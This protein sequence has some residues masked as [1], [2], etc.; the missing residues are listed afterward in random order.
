MLLY[1]RLH[2]T[3]ALP[4]AI[5]VLKPHAIFAS[6]LDP[7]Y[8][9]G[10]E[11][12]YS[13]PTLKLVSTFKRASLGFGIAGVYIS[14]LMTG[15]P[16]FTIE[17]SYIMAGLSV[18]PLPLVHFFTKDYVTRI[19]RVYNE[20]FQAQTMSSLTDEETL[21]IEKISF[22][23]NSFYKYL[24]KVEDLSLAEKKLGWINWKDKEGKG[25]YVSDDIGGLNM[26]RIWGKVEKQSGVDTGRSVE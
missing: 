24:V 21:V 22:T 3:R 5:K 16:L 15:T 4:E 20:D 7:K 17:A 1:R 14:Q 11:P 13:A 23:G 18:I 25:Y 19:F 6:E 26:D 9:L 10:H 8:R 12:L 2:T